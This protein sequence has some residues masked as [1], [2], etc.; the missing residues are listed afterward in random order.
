MKIL[1]IRLPNLVHNL[2][3]IRS[4][5]NTKTQLIAVVKAN[6]YGQGAV[7]IAH[8]LV[9]EGVDLLAVAYTEEGI[10]LRKAGITARIM[11]FYPQTENC[12]ALINHCLEPVL[13]SKAFLKTFLTIIKLQKLTA[14]PVHLKFNTGLNRIGFSQNEAQWILDQKKDNA[15]N[16]KSIYS[17]LAASEESKPHPQSSLQWQRFQEIRTFF[18]QA[19]P[20]V[21]FHILNTS[22]VFNYPEWQLDAVRVGIGLYGYANHPDWDTALKPVASLKATITQ[23]HYLQKGEYVGYNQGWVAT[24]STTTATIPIGHAD[25]IG[26]QF[27]HS[28]GAVYIKG[29]EAQIIGNVCM[30]LLMVDITETGGA[31][32]DEVIFFDSDKDLNH[33]AKKGK[34][35]PYELLTGLSKRIARQIIE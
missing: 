26:R 25:G 34:T 14:Y 16:I 31:E 22:G 24:K 30:D 10:A 29:K 13:Y 5:L 23:V 7:P 15:L 2:N 28:I 3:L 1:Q 20:D 6:A 33:W 11:V 17:H 27:G 12:N 19:I 9:A 21:Q 4:K 18:K 32:G 35:I 8:K